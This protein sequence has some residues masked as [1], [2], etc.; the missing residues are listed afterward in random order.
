MTEAQQ[1]SF[2]RALL[3][4][5][6]QQRHVARILADVWPHSL[7]PSEIADLIYPRDYRPALPNK[8]IAVA[9]SNLRRKLPRDVPW[10]HGDARRGYRL[11][12]AEPAE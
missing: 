4:V 2:E 6:P 9:V 3:R 11:E 1:K 8:S 7:F 5:S 10:V 12:I